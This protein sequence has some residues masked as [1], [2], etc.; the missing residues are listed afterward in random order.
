M[1]ATGIQFR[2]NLLL[3][4]D[5]MINHKMVVSEFKNK[6]LENSATIYFIHL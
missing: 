2:T 4:N 3:L 6:I 5:S 1:T